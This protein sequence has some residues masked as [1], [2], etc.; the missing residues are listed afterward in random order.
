M[1]ELNYTVSIH[2]GRVCRGNYRGSADVLQLPTKIRYETMA[3]KAEHHPW[4]GSRCETLKLSIVDAWHEFPL[5]TRW[6]KQKKFLSSS[7]TALNTYTYNASWFQLLNLHCWPWCAGTRTLL[8]Q[9]SWEQI[10]PGKACLTMQGNRPRCF[11]FLW[12]DSVFS[13]LLPVAFIAHIVQTTQLWLLHARSSLEVPFKLYYMWYIFIPRALPAVLVMAVV[14]LACALLSCWP[15]FDLLQWMVGRISSKLRNHFL[16]VQRC[17][18]PSD[19][20]III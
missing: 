18:V 19:Y 1:T 14:V 15:R 5:W 13:L 9:G 3:D 17:I 12:K 4:N 10:L 7:H 20:L 8:I 16:E 6:K 2:P 11:F